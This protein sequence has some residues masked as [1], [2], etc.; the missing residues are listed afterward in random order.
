[1]VEAFRKI[2]NKYDIERVA[3]SDYL[4]EIT[5]EDGTTKILADNELEE[6]ASE[7]C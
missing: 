5:L 2:L 4:Y 6:F 3:N 1:M 7:N